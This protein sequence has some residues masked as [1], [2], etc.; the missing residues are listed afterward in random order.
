[1]EEWIN[2]VTLSLNA[3][4]EKEKELREEAQAAGQPLDGRWAGEGM[5]QP[6]GM[7]QVV[8]VPGQNTVVERVVTCVEINQCVGCASVER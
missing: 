2:A 6:V 4:M 8:H 1:M 5:E 7:Q 3:E